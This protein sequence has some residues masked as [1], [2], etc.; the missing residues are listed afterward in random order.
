MEAKGLATTPFSRPEIE[1]R[2]AEMMAQQGSRPSWL[3]A[4][5]GK[6]RTTTA[7]ASANTRALRT[8]FHGLANS[9]ILHNSYGCFSTCCIWF[10]RLRVDA[11]LCL[12]KA[13]WCASFA[14]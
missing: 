12:S 6:I 7:Q 1:F 5:L 9:F 13:F 3:R 8:D 11:A 2:P 10:C 14:A 4:L